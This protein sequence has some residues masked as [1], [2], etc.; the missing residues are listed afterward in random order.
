MDELRGKVA[1]VTGGASGIG[2]GLA[3][4]FAAEGMHVVIAD[5]EEP[6]LA[7]TAEELGVIGVRTDVTDPASVQALA[8]AAVERFGTVQVICNNAGVG[9]GGRIRDL[10]LDDWRW[11]LDVNLWGV[12]HGLHS[13]LPLL[14]ANEDGGHV[15][16]TASLAG[17]AV[18]P[19]LGPYCATKFA[20]VGISETLAAELAGEDAKV[21]VSVL[22]PGF[23]RTNIFT[24]GRN[25]PAHLGQQAP[26]PVIPDDIRLQIEARSIEP[27][28]V[29]DDV[30]DAITH[31]TFWIFTHPE[32]LDN[33]ATRHDGIMAAAAEARQR[34]T[35]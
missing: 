7:A 5:V 32:M 10:S 3:A 22:C 13:F 12:I 29:A 26:A 34:A 20:V 15:V 1:V 14:L 23:V 21:H 35:S 17:V 8:D 27:A 2:K 16:N 25:R 33:V 30:V 28:Q 9:G 19:G 31:D 4:R 18:A 6:A 24:S 11:V